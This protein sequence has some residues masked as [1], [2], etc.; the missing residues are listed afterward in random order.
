L[1]SSISSDL[2]DTREQLSEA[3][4]NLEKAQTAHGKTKKSKAKK[5]VFIY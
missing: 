4:K 1:F 2:A 3:E 5:G